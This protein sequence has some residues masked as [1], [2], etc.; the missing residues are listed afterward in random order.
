M[1]NIQLISDDQ[2]FLMG[3]NA[4]LHKEY[5]LYNFI[6]TKPQDID[7]LSIPA[8]TDLIIVIIDNSAHLSELFKLV[9]STNIKTLSISRN[10]IDGDTVLRK[11]S[12]FFSNKRQS[13]NNIKNN[14]Q[15]IINNENIINIKITPA[16]KVIINYILQGRDINF[17]ARRLGLCHKTVSSH[18]RLF[19][20]QFRVD[21]IYQI[22]SILMLI[23]T[24]RNK[25]IT[26]KRQIMN[27]QHRY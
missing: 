9:N 19:L 22:L 6:L 2:Y 1:L 25:V 10:D 11:N 21:N 7:S 24:E 14:I 23:F 26:H 5:N 3:I 27:L 20:N 12:L 17:I 13:Q 18:K 8:T 16:Q 4:L 15:R